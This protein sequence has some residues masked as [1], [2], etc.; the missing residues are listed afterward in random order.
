LTPPLNP[1]LFIIAT[2]CFTTSQYSNIATYILLQPA[3]Q[4]FDIKPKDEALYQDKISGSNSFE[5]EETDIGAGCAYRRIFAS[6]EEDELESK[7]V[8]I[9]I[10]H[11]FVCLSLF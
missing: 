4:L 3:L 9:I 8:V 6:S 5:V 7:L 2:E 1:S 11:F 10:L